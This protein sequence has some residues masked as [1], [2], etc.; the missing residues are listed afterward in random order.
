MR[1][2]K[3]TGR[4]GDR[5]AGDR[6]AALK[7]LAAALTLL[8]C[9]G[10]WAANANPADVRWAQD[11][12]KSKGYDI[13]GRSAT[14]WNDAS[15]RA[16]TNFQRANGLPATGELDDATIA[17]LSAARGQSPTM[18][19]LGAPQSGG[20]ARTTHNEAA[21]QPKAVPTSRVGAQGGE[22]GVIGGVTLGRPSAPDPAP[23]ASP[24]PA[25]PSSS[26]TPSPAHSAAPHLA[27]PHV[28]ASGQ[29]HA[30]PVA[31]VQT[32]EEPPSPAAAP[33]AQ[34]TGGDGKP[35]GGALESAET[36]GGFQAANWMRYGVGGA[37]A[38]TLAAMGWGWWRSGRRKDAL[39]VGAAAF[40]LGDDDERATRHRVEPS[41]GA[42]KNSRSGLPPLTAPARPRH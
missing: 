11:I 32:M 37:L 4:S 42:A 25:S 18:G 13:G 34:V 19:T 16:L 33:R 15:K 5:R 2:L 12:L 35:A 26:R 6:L 27:A 36:G 20:G 29:P 14:T 21:P 30:A 17:K 8:A 41:F 22:S 38:A 31:R 7:T 39:A 40:D 1:G 10:A 23:S 28:A 24:S 9:G 3:R